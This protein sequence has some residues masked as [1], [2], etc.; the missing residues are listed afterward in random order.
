MLSSISALSPGEGGTSG[1]GAAMG[2]S[3]GIDP[4]YPALFVYTNRVRLEIVQRCR[5]EQRRGRQL[6][7]QWLASWQ[8][9]PIDVAA[10]LAPVYAISGSLSPSGK[11]RPHPRESKD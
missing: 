1:L 8:F 6:G 5:R 4:T 2:S 7:G 11:M 9:N 3:A 10:P